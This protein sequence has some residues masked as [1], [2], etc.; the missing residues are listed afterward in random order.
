VPAATHDNTIMNFSFATPLRPLMLAV[1]IQALIAVAAP[2]AAQMPAL[3]IPSPPRV[4]ADSFILLDFNTGRILAELDPDRAVEPASLTKLMTT[5]IVFAEVQS[6]RLA[7]DEE[8]LIS[9]RAWRMGGSQ[10]F[11]EV[12]MRVSVSDLLRGVIVQSGNDASVA[13][14]ERIGGTEEN[15]AL[16]MNAQAEAM[17]LT[18][19]RFRNATGL[20][21]EDHLVSAR[22]VALLSRALITQFP[23]LYEL[24]AERRF[25]FNEISQPNRNPLLGN[26]DGADGLKTGYTE[27]AG[28]CLAASAEREGM[29]LVSVVMG[30]SSPKA[31]AD[32]T[33]ALLNYGFHFYAT[34]RLYQA[35]E[36]ITTVPVWKGAQDEV[37]LGLDETL[38]ITIPRGSYDRLQA[39][40]EVNE[41]AIAP[42]QQA[43]PLGQLH[44]M[45]DD[46]V[47]AEAPLYTLADIPAGSFAKRTWDQIKLWFD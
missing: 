21:A 12:G 35:N 3:P 9:E 42:L 37:P 16:M 41:R 23:K 17:G 13:L 14:A 10:M 28:Y 40:T 29:R 36:T 1:M 18:T 8:V 26:F 38:Y 25:S 34:H 44:V 7:L 11:I 22:D 47:V 15:F 39:S 32:A 19:A 20:P 2:A 27:A 33:R 43:M 6:G 30:S 5:Y 4:D 45:L 24:F 46:S 31:R